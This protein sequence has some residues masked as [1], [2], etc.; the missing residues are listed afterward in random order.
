MLAATPTALPE[1]ARV[2]LLAVEDVRLLPDG[3]VAGLFQVYDPFADEPGPA[4]FYWVFEEVDGRWL[5]DEE[6]MLGPLTSGME[7]ATPAP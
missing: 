5:I 4:R 7:G 3:R 6:I 1:E 2:S